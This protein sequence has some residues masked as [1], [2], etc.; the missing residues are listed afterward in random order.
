MAL[1]SLV[2]GGLAAFACLLT[3]PPASAQTAD[4]AEPSDTEQEPEPADDTDED[5]TD[6][7][8]DPS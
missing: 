3:S 2:I 4:A 6:E 8:A 7:D 1:R 5:T